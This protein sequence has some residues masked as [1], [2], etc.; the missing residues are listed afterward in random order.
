[1][2]VLTPSRLLGTK[3]VFL[4]MITLSL[5]A[6][7]SNSSPVKHKGSLRSQGGL[8][9]SS[10]PYRYY[11]E[12]LEDADCKR[13]HEYVDYLPNDASTSTNVTTTTITARRQ[14]EP[15]PAIA[16]NVLV[17]LLQFSDHT[18][19]ELPAPFE[20]QLLWNLRIAQYLKVNSYYHALQQDQAWFDVIPWQVTDD[21]EDYYSSVGG[22]SS[23]RTL[24]F[25]A[26]IHPLLD[27]LDTNADMDWTIY[28]SNG[29]GIMDNLVVLHSGYSAELGG[30][31]CT[32][33]RGPVNR[34]WR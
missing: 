7:T 4:K 28:D 12:A 11:C 2:V 20:Y 15:N 10:V 1:M 19:R 30:N 23:G 29:D 34:I 24:D 9:R 17:L 21:S 3:R 22:S 8:E 6:R 27:A 18:A 33:Q 16:K 13:L 5:A 25:Q 32:N 31:D 26:A 14:L